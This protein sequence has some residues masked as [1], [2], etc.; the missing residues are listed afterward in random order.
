M[1]YTLSKG[2]RW[3]KTEYSCEIVLM[4][5]INWVPYTYDELPKIAQ[6]DAEIILEATANHTYTD[7]ELYY[8]SFYLVEEEAHP[9]LFPLD[10]DNPELLPNE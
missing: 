9:L 1:S 6:D 10:L 8:L 3:Y 5:F 7:E 4:H 2:Y